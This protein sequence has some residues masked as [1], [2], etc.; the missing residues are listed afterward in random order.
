MEVVILFV[1]SQSHQESLTLFKFDSADVVRQW[2][3]MGD[4][5]MGG[6]SNSKLGDH[7]QKNT[8]KKD[9]TLSFLSLFRLCVLNI[10]ARCSVVFFLQTKLFDQNFSKLYRR[11]IFG[12]INTL[13]NS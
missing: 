2:V 4:G 11:K 3:S 10:C 6:K 1:S 5:D 13:L 7:L 12:F 8:P 9:L